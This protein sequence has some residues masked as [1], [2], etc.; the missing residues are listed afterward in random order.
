MCESIQRQCVRNASGV[1]GEVQERFILQLQL[2][3]DVMVT[4]IR[5]RF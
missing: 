3:M 5:F 2:Y 1:K 4:Q